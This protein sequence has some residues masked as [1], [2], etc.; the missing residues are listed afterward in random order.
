MT[1]GTS[2]RAKG[3]SIGCKPHLNTCMRKGIGRD[4]YHPVLIQLLALLFL[5]PLE[6]EPVDLVRNT[7][8]CDIRR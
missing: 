5:T 2:L 8:R 4:D 3:L 7:Q 6:P 1:F